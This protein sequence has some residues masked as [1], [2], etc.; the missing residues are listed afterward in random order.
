MSK[1]V[2]NAK[3][4]PSKNRGRGRGVTKRHNARVR[5]EMKLLEDQTRGMDIVPK[6]IGRRFGELVRSL[7]PI[8][9]RKRGRA[10]G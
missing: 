10:R 4:K 1:R 2:S 9:R 7:I 3:G 6:D 5:A 8:N